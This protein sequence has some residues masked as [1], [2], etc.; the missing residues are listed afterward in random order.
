MIEI[1]QS[2]HKVENS[3][4]IVDPKITQTD[5]EASACTVLEMTNEYKA[6]GDADIRIATD[7]QFRDLS[8]LNKH[9]SNQLDYLSNWVKDIEGKLIRLTKSENEQ[10]SNTKNTNRS[11]PYDRPNSRDNYQSGNVNRYTNNTSYNR[12]NPE[13]Q[14]NNNKYSAGNGGSDQVTDVRPTYRPRSDDRQNY[15]ARSQSPLQN[16]ENDYT[17]GRT[18]YRSNSTN[19]RRRFDSP[20]PAFNTNFRSKSVEN[21]NQINQIKLEPL[22]ECLATHQHP[23]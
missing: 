17:R 23:N 20:K 19:F 9:N 10:F 15:R 12:Y 6:P 16:A 21:G 14:N 7:R 8:M 13:N 22:D 2:I 3:D 1:T 4:N 5:P 11:S 18:F